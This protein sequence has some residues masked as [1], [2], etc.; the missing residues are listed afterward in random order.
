MSEKSA[1]R[2]M[3][4]EAWEDFCE[5]L[6]QAGR[7]IDRFGP[8]E[9]DDQDRAEWFRFMGRVV[10]NGLERFGENC[11]PERPRLRDTPW[12]QAINFQSPDQDHFL[13]EFV[14]GSH[15]YIVRGNRGGLPYFVLASWTAPQPVHP[16][17]QSWAEA[18][19]DAL[20]RF[21]PSNLA[22]TGFI[23][24]DTIRFDDH[25]NFEITVSQND[26]GDG[27]DWLP[28]TP[29]CVGLLLRTLYHDRA[30]TEPPRFTIMRADD[31]EP[32]PVSSG[33]VSDALAKAGQTVLGYGELVRRWWQDNLAQRP[34]RIRFSRAVYLSNGGVPDR[35]HGFGTWEC[36]ADEALVIDFVPSPAQYWIFQLCN[37]WQEN[38]DSYEDGDGYVTKFHHTPAADGSVRIIV[39]E[40]PTRLAGNAI[41][42]FGHR[43]GGMS[44]RFIGLDENSTPPQVS[45]RR[46]KLQAIDEQGEA[47]VD[48]ATPV[49]SGELSE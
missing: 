1:Q 9:I 23:N 13:T 22:T 18:G 20:D 28:M 4:G 3:T 27:R 36:A 24:S 37:I 48:A 49:I 42:T 15:D 43:H 10:R 35:H 26:P 2:L 8:D 39:S 38:L 31:P 12:R 47:A 34:N 29:D 30:T 14:D 7:I 6:K 33:E 17:E 25:G 19:L 5:Q 45:L 46:I 21:D 40:E 44:L 16:G 11:E 41:G 32:Q